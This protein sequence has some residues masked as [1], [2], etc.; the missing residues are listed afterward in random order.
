MTYSHILP[1]CQ[2]FSQAGLQK[3]GEEGSGT[4]SSLLFECRRA[5]VAKKPKYL[6]LENV[7]ALVSYKFLPTFNKW[8]AEL[9]EYGYT[10]FAQVLNAK[11]YNIPQNRERIFLVSILDSNAHFFFPEKMPLTRK[12]QDV[13]EPNVDAKYYLNYGKVDDFVKNNLDMIQSYARSS[14][15]EIEPLTDELKQLVENWLSE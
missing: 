5:I 11:D 14:K 1:P 8:R 10:N 3:G 9:H 12:L 13:L 15:E 7:S 2:D 4:R 6:I